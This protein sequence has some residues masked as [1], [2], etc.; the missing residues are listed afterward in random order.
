MNGYVVVAADAGRA[1]FFHLQNAGDPDLESGPNLV[2]DEVLLN[3][4]RSMPDRELFADTKSGRNRSKGTSPHG[5]DDHR[6]RHVREFDRKFAQRIAR[7]TIGRAKKLSSS[8]IVIAA[9]KRMLGVL[10]TKLDGAV[11]VGMQILEFGGDLSKFAPHELHR[12]LADN[13][14]IP[15]RRDPLASRPGTT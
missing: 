5:Y 13:K 10:R 1:R 8:Y 3:P 12:K 11:N 2:E 7:K 14:L 6:R 9:D 4:E 15:R